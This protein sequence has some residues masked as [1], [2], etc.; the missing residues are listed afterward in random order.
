VVLRLVVAADSDVE[1]CALPAFVAGVVA[2]ELFAYE[3]E[4]VPACGAEVEFAAPLFLPK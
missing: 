1:L 4:L 3:L 2:R